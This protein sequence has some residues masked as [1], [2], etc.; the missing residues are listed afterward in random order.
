MN[1]I[2]KSFYGEF[3]DNVFVE[4]TSPEVVES[5]A[6]VNLWHSYNSAQE[7][8][9]VMIS[10]A[11]EVSGAINGALIPL[12]ANDYSVSLSQSSLFAIQYSVSGKSYEYSFKQ[13]AAD[14]FADKIDWSVS[15]TITHSYLTE[16]IES[17]D[18]SEQRVSV[19]D[20]PRLSVNYQVPV[21]DA[22]R[23]FYESRFID[24]TGLVFVPLWPLQADIAEELKAGGDTIQLSRINSYLECADYVAV[25]DGGSI[26]LFEVEGIAGGR[27]KLKTLAQKDF[28]SSSVL[29]PVVVAR[30]SD[31][32]DSA[33]IIDSFDM[34]KVSFQADE[35]LFKKPNY[36]ISFEK[37]HVDE[38]TE[39]FDEDYSETRKVGERF[40][41]P[42]RPDR[43]SDISMQYNRLRETFDPL[44]GARSVY[45]RTKG[46]VRVFS[47]TYK[48]FSE[49]ERQRFEDFADIHKGAQKEFYFEGPGR[50]IDLLDQIA[51]PTRFIKAAK[52]GLSSRSNSSAPGLAFKLYNGSTVYRAIKNVVDNLD[53]T[54][55]IELLHEVENIEVESVVPLFL[56]RFESDDFTY[57][58][59]TTDV[60]QIT[61]NIRQIINAD[62]IEHRELI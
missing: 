7:L 21:V 28:S 34:H 41:F 22:D 13:D 24:K 20:K 55:T 56:A 18:G 25:S 19:R 57:T 6:T 39:V 1:S 42:F 8:D 23:Y 49:E 62:T 60:S 31:S 43:S 15:P 35:V 10:G 61:K 32:S 46:A 52:C 33:S 2:A 26:D 59:H 37:L 12:A 38:V 16:V 58:F 54:E 14:L 5:K 53:G 47:C 51:A 48:F 30:H 11:N 29:V 17:F 36:K 9:G 50:F 4:K 27:V 3:R 44:I 40:I 45:E